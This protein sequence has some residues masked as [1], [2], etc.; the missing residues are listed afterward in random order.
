MKIKKMYQGTAPENKILNTQSNSQ[1]DVYSC[2]YVNKL[3]TYSTD[4]HIIGTWITGKPVYRKV[5]DIDSITFSAGENNIEHGISNM[6]AVV[7]MDLM[8]RYTN[9]NW[10][11]N[12]DYYRNITV[13]YSLI[14]INIA[15]DH[16]GTTDFNDG[17]IILE[18]TKTTD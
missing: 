14:T 6:E 10:Y 16:A 5:I 2:D 18:Y 11:H 7:R 12:W 4:E 9:E 1:T 15:S 3:N 8:L 17:H 13:S